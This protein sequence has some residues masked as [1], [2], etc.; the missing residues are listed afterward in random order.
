M[1]R[2]P[3]SPLL[4][5]TED[6]LAKLRG[7][8]SRDSLLTDRADFGP[9]SH[10][11]TEDLRSS[12]AAV[13]RPKNS[14]EVV[15]VVRFAHTHRIALTPRGAGSGLSG[16]AIPAHGGIVLSLDRMQQIRSLDADDMVAE[17]EA[18]VITGDLMRA[19]A[20]IGLL[21]GPNPSSFDICTVGGNIA[22]N[23]A[24]PLSLRYGTTR[25]QVLGLEIV[26]ADGTLVRCGGRNRKDVAGYD[27]TRLLVGS[28]GTL[29]V[30]TAATLRLLPAP[31]A[32]M[33][34]LA[35]FP[36]LESAAAAVA[37]VC[38]EVP[39]VAA[40]EMVEAEAI[41]AVASLE[42]VPEPLRSAGAALLLEVHCDQAEHLMSI[43]E[44]ILALVE[45]LGSSD[46]QVALDE[47]DERKLWH[48]RRQ[49]AHAVKSLSVYKE[50][51]TVVPRS[52]LAELVRAAR[53]VASQEGLK[54]ICYGHAGD[55][56]LHINLLRGTLDEERWIE[57]RDR[58][59][60]ALFDRV[61]ALGGSITGEH[62]IGWTQRQHLARHTPPELLATMRQI[63]DVFDPLGIL[64]P[65]KIFLDQ[66]PDSEQE[67]AEVS[68]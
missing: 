16:G 32:R 17:V 59:E 15:E 42:T 63:K 26:L 64:N 37:T 11:E 36:D 33:S 60:V 24:G 28:E 35:T 19:A 8:L 25:D 43:A 30:I 10:D 57:A 54:A 51:D 47:H 52:R 5:L 56:N 68:S 65:S 21:Y 2:M 39:A 14:A 13:V 49:V 55:G 50:V 66:H 6:H 48:L 22:E 27:L 45:P 1:R 9:Y 4:P 20:Q 67:T 38:R 46:L 3:N 23:A 53:E 44:Q 12:P 31:A 18:G 40:C 61:V 58:A 41:A 7:L 62:G 34:L 29:A